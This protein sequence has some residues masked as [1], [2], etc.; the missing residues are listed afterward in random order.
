MAHMHLS[1]TFPVLL[2]NSYLTS[3]F[4]GVGISEEFGSVSSSKELC[5]GMNAGAGYAII[6][7]G[8]PEYLALDFNSDAA[9]PPL[10]S[11]LQEEDG[12]IQVCSMNVHFFFS[13]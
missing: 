6:S 7:G 11:I 9:N 2:P 5:D 8:G 3:F 12:G 10:I 13:A 4:N 1:A